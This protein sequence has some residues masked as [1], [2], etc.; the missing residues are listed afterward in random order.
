MND[1]P[2]TKCGFRWTTECP[3]EV[4]IPHEKLILSHTPMQDLLPQYQHASVLVVGAGRSLQAA[5]EYGF[6]RALS[7]RQLAAALGP[8]AAPFSSVSTSADV[9]TALGLP[10]PVEVP[11]SSLQVHPIATAPHR[12]SPEG[13]RTRLLTILRASCKTLLCVRMASSMGNIEV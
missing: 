5:H 9:S 4:Q 2:R 7:P 11:S 8:D 1:S 3:C 12:T 13:C 10:C 6:S